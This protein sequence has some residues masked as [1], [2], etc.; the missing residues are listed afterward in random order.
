MF[1]ELSGQRTRGDNRYPVGRKVARLF[2]ALRVGN[3]GRED[4]ANSEG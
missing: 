2:Q 3:S 1:L 4:I